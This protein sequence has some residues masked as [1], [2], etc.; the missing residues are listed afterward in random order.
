MGYSLLEVKL[1][2]L[3]GAGLIGKQSHK[4]GELLTIH[5]YRPKDSEEADLTF[6]LACQT[7]S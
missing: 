1:R 7:V 3:G 2:G 4:L 5:D 6:R